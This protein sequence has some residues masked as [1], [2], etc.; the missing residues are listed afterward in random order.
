VPILSSR[1]TRLG[2]IHET[3]NKTTERTL[4]RLPL[5]MHPARQI[6]KVRSVYAAL[7]HPAGRACP[8]HH[9]ALPARGSTRARTRRCPGGVRG[10]TIGSPPKH[11][12]RTEVWV[13]SGQ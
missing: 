7:V 5:G 10:V 2:S 4:P 11:R 13:I 1:L 6:A 12:V 9:D 8:D 3:K